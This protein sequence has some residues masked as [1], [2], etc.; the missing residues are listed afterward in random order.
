MACFDVTYVVD[1]PMKS[2]FLLNNS[3]AFWIHR[4][5]HILQEQFNQRLKRYDVSWPQWMVLNVLHTDSTITPAV[6]ASQLGID[7]SGVTR[8]L[9]RLE[10]KQYL[11]REHDKLDRRS[12]N[13]L[14]TAKGKSLIDEMNDIAKQ[15]QDD[16][17]KD[18]HSSERLAYKKVMQK[19]LKT[20][21]IDSGAL[22][23]RLD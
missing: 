17:L 11:T 20:S 4:L 9:D 15:H 12:V 2:D 19:M 16:F 22:W 8:L 6:I 7:R 1:V 14:L 10:K 18:L 3:F 21:G 5:N 23:Q 13:L